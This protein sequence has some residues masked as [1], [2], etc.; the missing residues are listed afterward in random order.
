VEVIMAGGLGDVA[1]EYWVARIFDRK[2]LYPE[3][4]HRSLP[5]DEEVLSWD[6]GDPRAILEYLTRLFEDPM[7]Y[8]GRYSARQLRQGLWYL[9]DN[10]CSS[11]MFALMND[12]APW[13]ER[14]RCLESFHSLYEKLFAPLCAEVLS[15]RLP[16]RA[17]PLWEE[18]QRLH[19][20]MAELYR[21][22]F[23]EPA[24]A[25]LPQEVMG[26]RIRAWSAEREPLERELKAVEASA[27]PWDPYPLNSIC[28]MWWDVLP[29]YGRPDEPEQQAFDE[30][31]LNVLERILGLESMAC[32]E[33]A[34]H[35][36]GHWRSYYPERVERTVDRFITSARP[37]GALLEYARQARGGCIL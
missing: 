2:I 11:Y 20:A 8:L 26:K 14:R 7:P 3:W 15:H 29:V 36:L 32:R 9:A 10:A 23:P 18:E 31:V 34:L 4:Y 16:P 6:R 12:E 1:F 35:G 37:E 22:H 5:E 25:E 19:R 33:G 28:Y 13:E 21:K 30:T 24:T 17:D 27:T